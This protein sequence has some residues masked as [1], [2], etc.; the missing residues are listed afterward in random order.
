MTEEEQATIN[1]C[2]VQIVLGL[3]YLIIY[4]L[5][6]TAYFGQ[7]VKRTCMMCVFVCVCA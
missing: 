6:G 5:E 3:L 2:L 1:V 4:I 7:N